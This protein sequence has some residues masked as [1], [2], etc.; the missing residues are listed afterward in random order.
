MF[1]SKMR[2]YSVGIVAENKPLSSDVA[3][4]VPIE[5]LPMLDGELKSNPQALEES[6]VDGSGSSYSVSAD[7]DITLRA[8]WLRW[9]TNRQ[10][11][12]DVRRGERVL[13]W[14]YADTDTFYWTSLGMDNHLRKLETVRYAISATRDEDDVTLTPENTYSFEMSSHGK[15]INI[16]T[17]KVD[18]EPYSY[19][20][21]INTEDGA[22]VMKDDIGNY[23]EL[24]SEEHKITSK[25][26]DGTEWILDKKELKGYAKDFCEI[27]VDG[28]C[29]IIA[30]QIH[31]G[32]TS[33][34]QNSVL[35]DNLAAAMTSLIQQINN[36]KVIGNLG[37]PTSP[38]SA[39]QPVEEPNLESGGNSYSTVNKNQ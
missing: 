12:P 5:V 8:K 34:L 33:A 19:T 26:A 6:G 13:L 25:N 1:L 24:D 29:H 30:P 4:I 17:S 11:A 18:G 3:V 37:A 32:E 31:L 20:I 28:P 16:Q 39:V 36:S 9:D 38:I 2:I 23:I 10:T 27:H 35:G 22:I 15:Y 14:Q 7:T 21:Q